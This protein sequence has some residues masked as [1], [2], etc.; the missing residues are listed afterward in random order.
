MMTLIIGGSGSGKSAFAEQYIGKIAEG[1]PKYYI[2]TMKVYD[3]EGKRKVEKHRMQ[4]QGKEFWTVECPVDI[5]RAAKNI[6]N[7][8]SVTLL[9]CMSNL[10]ANEMFTEQGIRSKDEVVLKVLRGIRALNH[11]VEELVI[12]TNNVSEEGT[13][14]D[15]DTIDYICSLGEINTLLAREAERVAEVVVGI[16]IWMK[17]GE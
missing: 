16:P 7:K 14:Y 5:E 15:K 1:R 9:E 10:V 17:G 11:Q 13:N 4:R 2:A 12:V 3:E 6:E 8:K